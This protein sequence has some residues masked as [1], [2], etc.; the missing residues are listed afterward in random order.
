[1]LADHFQVA[2]DREMFVDD[3]VPRLRQARYGLVLVNRLVF[4][5]DSPG[6]ELIHAM[7]SDPSLRD[8]PVMLISNYPEAQAEA[9][10]AGGEPGFGKACLDDSKTLDLL[11]R[12]LPARA[13][14]AVR[15]ENGVRPWRGPDPN[16]AT[17]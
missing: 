3:A 2:V 16:E 15:K 17:I 8:V 1:M 12:Y 4:A 13:A 10:A 9:R 11:G 7:K 6:I 14:G 5:D